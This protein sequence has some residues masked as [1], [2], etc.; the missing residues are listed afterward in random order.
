MECLDANAVQDLMSDALAAPA[1]AAVMGHLDTCQDCRDLIGAVARDT[2]RESSREPGGA[3]TDGATPRRRI[4]LDATAVAQPVSGLERT[5][6]KNDALAE[7]VAGGTDRAPKLEG[8]AIGR[9]LGRYTLHEQLGAGAMGIVYRADDRELARSVAVKILHRPDPALTE[10]LVR[11][12]RS[13]AQ[14]SHPNVVGVYDVGVA[15]DTTYIAMELVQGTSLR[16]WQEAPRTTAELIEAYVAAGRG[17][18]AAHAAGIVHRDFKPDNVL[19]GN[20]G[21]VRVTDFG[22]AAARP[23]ET[24][25]KPRLGELELTHSGMVLGTPA[26]MAPEQ[27]LGGNVDART[28]QFSFC[29]ALHEALYRQRPFQGKSYEDLG[30]QVCEGRVRPPPQGAGVSNELRAIVLRGLSVRPGDRY[31]TMD[32]LLDDLARD[33]ARPWRRASIAA[34]LLAIVL[35]FGLVADWAVRDRVSG[36]IRQAFAATAF[37]TDRAVRLLSG[38]LD[39]MGNQIYALPVMRKVAA[40]HDEA[41]FGLG[42]ADVDRQNLEELH[43]ELAST[44]WKYAR[45]IAGK[46]RPIVIAV[47]DYKARLLYTS[48][49]PT[50]WNTSLIELPWI[51][52]A[53][54]AG[55]GN[56]M[57]LMRFDDPRLVAT[58]ILG[59]TPPSGLAVVFTRTLSLGESAKSQFLQILDAS[60]VLDNIRLDD[61]TLLSITT[62]DGTSSGTVP[63]PLVAASAATDGIHEQTL[64]G[65]TYQV[66]AQPIFGPD[67]QLVGRVV[68]ARQLGGVLTLF[69]HARLVFALAVLAAILV[70]FGTLWRARRLAHV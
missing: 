15:K 17:L 33:R 2:I 53:L 56:S 44:D 59:P 58:Q 37:Q 35:G 67:G 31:P 48:A 30:D 1:R 21:R 70:A 4:D 19:V 16:G 61:A 50:S 52:Q 42:S 51:K 6:V 23:G 8:I 39:A 18:A 55:T 43:E 54:D 13:M 38:Q 46:E 47:A 68:M 34:A 29:V 69:A 49:S 62:A 25:A 12:A 57:R 14:V 32:H 26:Y 5:Q 40:H 66:Q 20:D 3:G 27:F 11:E 10:R 7:T 9:E 65:T 60:Y 63:P 24:I 36:Q 41:D 45:E 64:G 28:D 22:L